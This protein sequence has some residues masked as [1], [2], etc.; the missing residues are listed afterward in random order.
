MAYPEKHYSITGDAADFPEYSSVVGTTL[1]AK[2]TDGKWGYISASNLQTTLDGA[3][4]AT[5]ADIAAVS[6]SVATVVTMLGVSGSTATQAKFFATDNGSG[7]NYKVGDDAWIGDVNT[8]NVMQVSGVQNS[9]S[10]FIKFGSGSA[11]P[12]LGY[13]G[14]NSHLSLNSA[15]AL[16]PQA[17]LGSAPTGSLAV[18]GSHLYFFN[19]AWVQII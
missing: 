2:N 10:G 7:T 8:S 17:T 6:A 16:A 1:L 12:V 15:L 19:G 4:L 5:D 18:S 14:S 13:S 9:G 3:G 11:T